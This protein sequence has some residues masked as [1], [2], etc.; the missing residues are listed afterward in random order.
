M[1]LVS[2]QTVCEYFN[3]CSLSRHFIANRIFSW[4]ICLRNVLRSRI[5]KQKDLEKMQD[6]FYYYYYGLNTKTK[7]DNSAVDV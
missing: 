7:N 6:I 4:K 2:F 5:D 1:Q 3:F